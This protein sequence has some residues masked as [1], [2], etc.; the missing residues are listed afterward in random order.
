MDDDKYDPS[1]LDN[2]QS[3]KVSFSSLLF[4]RVLK[5]HLCSDW[6]ETGGD[7]LIGN[8]TSNEMRMCCLEISHQFVQ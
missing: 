6:V 3:G 4:R 2:V 5:A 7:E 8:D 1:F